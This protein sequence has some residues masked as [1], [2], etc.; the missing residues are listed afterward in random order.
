MKK[1]IKNTKKG[2]LM[3]AMLA[4]S[5]SFANEGT[6]F[7][8]LASNAKKTSLTLDYV[9]EGNTLYIKD[10]YGVKLYEE[11]IKSNGHYVKGFDLTALPD[12][13]YHFE[14][15]AEVQI[16]VIPFTVESNTIK[17]DTEMA[18]TIF[19][20]TV[21]IKDDL[22]FVSK[23]ALNNEPL[24]IEVYYE[25]LNS[26]ELVLTETIK[27][28]KN[29]QRVYKLTDDLKSGDYKIVF[30]TNGREFTKFINN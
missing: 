9:K 10:S 28:T 12:G 21:R 29:I 20:P 6:P 26:S 1:V 5:L 2:I 24:K 25:K 17:F 8:R 23:L 19:K 4:A 7:F 27:D 3:V 30:T 18:K 14:L 22:V 16:K 15:D 13:A 11:L